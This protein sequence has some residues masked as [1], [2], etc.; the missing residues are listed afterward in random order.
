MQNKALGYN[1]KNLTHKS[2]DIWCHGYIFNHS[3]L[4][5]NMWALDNAFQ[6]RN[7]KNVP[8]KTSNLI[9]IIC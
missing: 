8:E 3:I 6:F 2:I 9:V 7:N 1:N 4:Q 5:G